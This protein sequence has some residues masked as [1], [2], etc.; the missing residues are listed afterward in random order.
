MR[1]ILEASIYP[2]PYVRPA[3]YRSHGFQGRATHGGVKTEEQLP[4]RVARRP[5][6]KGVTEKVERRHGI[7]RAPIAI[8]A[9]HNLR[10]LGMQFQP[11]LLKAMR[12]SF[13]EF[14]GLPQRATMCESVV[15]VPT[16]GNA[17]KVPGH[18][19]IKRVV[20]KQVAQA[21]ADTPPPL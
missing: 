19:D 20:Q 13:D 7:A 17:R 18:P 10:L 9:I 2:I 21:W 11:T 5:S 16:P 15:R 8:L 3:N 1:D 6:T 4:L 14:S 12:Q